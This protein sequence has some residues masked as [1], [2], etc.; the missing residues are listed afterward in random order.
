MTAP[1]K[2]TQSAMKDFLSYT[3]GNMCGL[4]YVAKYFD[5]M[6][7]PA[8]DPMKLGQYFE[9][10]ATGAKTKFGHTPVAEKTQAGKLTTNYQRVEK[11]VEN[12]KRMMDFYGFK[13]EHVAK[14][15]QHDNSTGDFDTV[16]LLTKDIALTDT[17]LPEGSRCI[18]DLKY[19]GLLYDKWNEMGWDAERLP[20]KESIMTQSVHYTWL[21]L[22]VFNERMPF[23]F[24]VFSSTNETDHELFHI[25]I[26]EER[27][28][29]HEGFVQMAYTII[30]N[31]YKKG[32]KPH[33]HYKRCGECPLMPKC[34]YAISV[35]QIKTINY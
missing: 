4:Q 16:V 25:N 28:H 3:N 11:Q 15:I 14:R 1:F 34:K 35:P 12:F 20:E 26:D 29:K 32:F 2:V 19:S 5:G 13:I 10:M 21:G 30:Q 33:A 9:Y 17:L 24:A 22:K 31:E 18:I 6:E 23:F 27:I 8:S 7:F